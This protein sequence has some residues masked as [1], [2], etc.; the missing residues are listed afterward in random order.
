MLGDKLSAVTAL[1]QTPT[2]ARSL[3]KTSLSCVLSLRVPPLTGS[4]GL[5]LTLTNREIM[6]RV[7][8]KSWMLNPLRHPGIPKIFC[9]L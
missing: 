7:E 9:F 2:L 3:T 1:S 8:I 4:V 6:T 5:F